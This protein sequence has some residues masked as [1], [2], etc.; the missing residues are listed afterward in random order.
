METDSSDI[1]MSPE[2]NTEIFGTN[3]TPAIVEPPPYTPGDSSL[4]L[5]R[6]SDQEPQM[7]EVLL[8]TSEIHNLRS[9]TSLVANQ[10]LGED[11]A[12]LARSD[13][14]DDLSELQTQHRNG[15][16]DPTYLEE[17]STVYHS[18]SDSY[19]NLEFQ[20][21]C[22]KDENAELRA[23]IA[24][25]REGAGPVH[26]EAYFKEKIGGLNENIKEWSMRYAPSSSSW[27]DDATTTFLDVL[28]RLSPLGKTTSRFL[29]RHRL[30]DK[31]TLFR[32]IRTRR[33][34]YAH[35]LSLGLFE[36]VLRTFAFGLSW[37]QNIT[38]NDL[39]DLIVKQGETNV[40]KKLIIRKRV[41]NNTVDS[42]SSWKSCFTTH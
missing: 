6:S 19:R 34:F 3:E 17:N 29:M 21:R 41:C 35:M 42:Q 24:T 14:P 13:R 5:N 39:Q 16:Q 15:L 28:E 31:N 10:G 7:D 18:L 30:W 22:L 9:D 11:N 38:L 36:K 4:P 25:M 20:N 37:D 32:D 1:P 27:R 8:H 40:T 2:S 33:H 12:Q 26:D 23:V